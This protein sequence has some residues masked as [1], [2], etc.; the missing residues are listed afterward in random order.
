[1]IRAF[2]FR[3]TSALQAVLLAWALPALAE[4]EA[5]V[6]RDLRADG[7]L[8]RQQHLPILLVLEQEG[9]HYCA[10]LEREV[11]RPMLASGDYVGKKV[12]L[13]KLDIAGES[14][15]RDFDGRSVTAA[16]FARRYKAHV[17]PTLLFLDQDGRELAPKMVGVSNLDFYWSYLDEALDTALAK[18]EPCRPG[19]EYRVAG[20]DAGAGATLC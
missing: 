18:L 5:P 17:T 15:L 7:Q 6:A 19:G 20:K 2:R 9:C 10:V 16:E 14:P 11:I 1:M 8:S 3:L 12:I 4:I 13:R